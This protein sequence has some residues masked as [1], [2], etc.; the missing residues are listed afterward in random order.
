MKQPFHDI[1]LKTGGSHYPMVGGD[2]LVK[3]G[4]NVV[5]ECVK[6]LEQAAEYN[7]ELYGVVLDILEHFDMEMEST[8]DQKAEDS[9]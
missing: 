1:A 2:L 6:I 5:E 4:E 9:I 8:N 7:P 3:F